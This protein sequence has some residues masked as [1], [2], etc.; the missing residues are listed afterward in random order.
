[1]DERLAKGYAKQLI[2]WFDLDYKEAN[3]EFNKALNSSKKLFESTKSFVKFTH[4]LKSIYKNFYVTT[5]LVRSKKRPFFC[6]VTF[7]P[8]EI[9]YKDWTEKGLSCD[10]G[11]L[12]LSANEGLEMKMGRYLI[13]EHAISRTFQRSN[14]INENNKHNPYIII[15]EFKF[16][17]LWSN[18]WNCLKIM[19]EK[20]T[21]NFNPIIPASN[22]VFY[23]EYRQST[24][25]SFTLDLR[26]YVGKEI[27]TDAQNN[28]REKM[29]NASTNLENC[30][31]SFLPQKAGN[32]EN[33]EMYE[34]YLDIYHIRN[35]MSI[36]FIVGLLLIYLKYF[37]I[38]FGLIICPIIKYFLTI[39]KWYVKLNI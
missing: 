24:D 21:L 16:V 30:I 36:G 1:M 14:I 32:Y 2:N 22:G 11:Y 20:E 15:N 13:G 9:I 35:I 25:Q 4:K 34:I 39:K 3:K 29:L 17:P 10:I 8:D 23:C 38:G 7:Q 5:L 33:I 27:L 18:F 31:F 37:I 28:L 6:Y 12:S 26:T 19:L